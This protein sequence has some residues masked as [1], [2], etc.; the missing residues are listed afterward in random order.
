MRNSFLSNIKHDIREFSKLGNRINCEFIV[1][2]C[3]GLHK[4]NL[5][6]DI[7][8]SSPEQ[9]RGWFVELLTLICSSTKLNWSTVLTAIMGH[10][11][12]KKD[13]FRR[14]LEILRIN[15]R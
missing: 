11:V 1:P 14:Q 6:L 10:H 4:N 13:P 3:L 2:S 5:D 12:S 8:K 15:K 7:S 9:R